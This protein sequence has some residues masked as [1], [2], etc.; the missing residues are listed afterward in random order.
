MEGRGEHG[1]VE[2]WW[3]IGVRIYNFSLSN[4]CYAVKIFMQQMLGVS[5]LF[6]CSIYI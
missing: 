1:L 4:F 5:Q 2:G 6:L 3:S